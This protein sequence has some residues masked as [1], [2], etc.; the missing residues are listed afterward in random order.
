MLK[1]D[2][3]ICI[4]AR[5]CSTRLPAK[6]F[7]SFFREL[8][9]NRIIRISKNITNSKNIYILSGNKKLN[10]SLSVIAKK[11]KLK[12]FYGSEKNVHSRFKSFL[13]NFQKKPKYVIRVT[14]D[15]Y[16]IQPFLIKKM[17][18]ICKK[19]DFD[20]SYVKPLS[21]YAG[22]IIKSNLFFKKK[23]S[24]KAKEHV[25]W[26]MRS[27]KDIKIISFPDNFLGI[28]HKKS[29]TLDSIRDFRNLIKLEHKYKGLKKINCIEEIK[30]IKL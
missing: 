7:L 1:K 21:H 24:S 26:D 23:P 29:I 11:N 5:L 4:Q 28:N 19:K 13:S 2:F 16:L 22:E 15:N 10:Q 25:T 17:L 20:Y 27:A 14:S 6:I 30:K 9:I 18:K 12:I 8:I 3:I